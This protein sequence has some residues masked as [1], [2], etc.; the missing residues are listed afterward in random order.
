M[1]NEIL[2]LPS[3]L[4]MIISYK[5]NFILIEAPM[6]PRTLKA[7]LFFYVLILFAFSHFGFSV[8]ISRVTD[9]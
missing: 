6:L 3:K 9:P 4:R 5:S 2:K 7:L 8:G 1:E